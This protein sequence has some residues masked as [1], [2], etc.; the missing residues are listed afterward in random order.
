MRHII[1]QMDALMFRIFWGRGIV[2]ELSK[3][4]L[5]NFCISVVFFT[6]KNEMV[7]VL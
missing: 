5:S 1:G 2:L 7:S 3:Y 6:R 4:L